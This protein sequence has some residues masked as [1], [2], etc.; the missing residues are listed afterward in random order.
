M[1]ILKANS[2]NSRNHGLLHL[3]TTLEDL[4]AFRNGTRVLKLKSNLD[5][6]TLDF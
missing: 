1:D 6:A 2:I 4:K 5:Q 3:K